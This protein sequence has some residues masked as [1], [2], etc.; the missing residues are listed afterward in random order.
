MKHDLRYFLQSLKKQAPELLRQ[1]KREV[2]PQWELSAVQKRLEVQKRLPV[3]SFDRVTGSKMPVVTNLFASRAHLALALEVS[4]DE[5]VARFAEAQKNGLPTKTVST[6]PVKDI[7]LQGDEATLS[8]LPL[9]THCEKDAG[10]Y[11][12]SG[13]TVMRDPETGKL[14]AGIYRNLRTSPTS[15]TM[16]MAP[17]CHGAE[18]LSRAEAEGQHVQAAIIVGHHPALCM[19]SQQRGELGDFELD[20]MGALVEEP[21]DVVPA[22]TVDI[23]VPADAEIV[24][25]GTIRTDT[26]ADDG[27]FGDYWLY[28]APAKRARVFEI[29]AITHRHDAIFHDIFNVGPE[30]LVLFSL[31]M[32]GVVF[33]QLKRIVPELQAIHVPVCGSGNLVYVQIKKGID[34]QGINAALAALGA[35]RFKC[36][37]VVDEDVDI[38]DDGK[39]LWAMMTRTQA[40][41][42]IF[43]VPG[44][45]VSR[46][47]PTGYP[48]W[49][50]GDEGARLLSTRL[51]IDATK[52]MDPAF[53][54][55]AEPPRELW[56]TLDLARYID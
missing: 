46:V 23:P 38:Y 32:E 5:V 17:L 8:K 44:S 24:I 43:T 49:Q 18:I 39:V 48:A 27:P 47:D 10:P 42:S 12:T 22:E 15:L 25:E 33:D 36:A 1:V 55:V 29:T 9:I 50:M 37:I 7:V 35:Y 21:V 51:G 52:P 4:P 16:N 54:E 11:L 28:Y 26:W 34:G 56:T 20:T 40:D 14:N 2:S 30:H 41:R 45:Y 53:P 31:G 6:G 19:A 3:L 13:V